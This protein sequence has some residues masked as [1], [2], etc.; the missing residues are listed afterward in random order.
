MNS[1]ETDLTGV[2]REVFED[3]SIV[4]RPE[5]SAS[6]IPTWDSLMHIQLVVAVEKNFGIRFAAGEIEKL[7]NVGEM[8]ALIAQKKAAAGSPSL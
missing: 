5:T 6:D 2:F 8:I 7:Q 1:I 3:P 4:I